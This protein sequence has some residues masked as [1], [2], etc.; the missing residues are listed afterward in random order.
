MNRII[1]FRAWNKETK[2]IVDLNAITP[3]ALAIIPSMVGAGDGVYVPDDS[4]LEVM[5]FTG[6]L[7]S[8]GKE[9]WEG[10]IIQ[11]MVY[12]GKAVIRWGIEGE[13]YAGWCVEW[14]VDKPYSIPTYDLLYFKNLE[15]CEVIGNIYENPELV[16]A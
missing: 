3:F 8:Q 13:T 6:L 1:K 16:N 12:G 2:K 7:D 4:R 15:N 14:I 9:I 10:D 5:Q 11:N